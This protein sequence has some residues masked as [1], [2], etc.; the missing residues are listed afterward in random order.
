MVRALAVILGAL[1][2]ATGAW[3]EDGWSSYTDEPTTDPV[4]PPS[5][6]VPTPT[7]E[8]PFV[9][10]FNDPPA[11]EPGKPGEPGPQGPAGAKGDKG[12]KGDSADLCQNIDGV[13]TTPGRKYNAQRYWSFKPKWEKRYLA[14]NRK[15][16]IV[17]VT[18]RWIRAHA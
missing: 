7:V 6:Y 5:D 14:T 8:T 12:D 4:G 15:G 9:I 16:Q 17:C 3:A 2:L 1:A 10:P 13:Q 11:G 18:L